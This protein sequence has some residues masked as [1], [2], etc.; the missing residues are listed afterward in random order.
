M[1]PIAAPPA[2]ILVLGGAG[3]IGRTLIPRLDAAGHRITVPTRRRERARPL[4]L[5]PKTDV[6]ECDIQDDATLERLLA[7]QTVVINLVGLLHGRPG[8]PDDPFGPDF[9]KAHVT[10]MERLVRLMSAQRVPRLIQVSALGVPDGD[11]ATAPSRYLRSKAAA[12]RL[13]RESALDWTI[14]RPS[15]VFGP[16]DSFLTLFAGLQRLLPVMMVA[17]ADA[18]FQPV[19]AGDVAT[20][21]AVSVDNRTTIGRTFELAGPR[22]YTLAELIRLTGRAS[23]HRRPVI[24]LPAG[25]GRLQALVLEKMPGPTLMS[26]DNLLSMQ[27]DNVA[28]GPI[29]PLF[30]ITPTPIEAIAPSYL[31][32]T[33]SRFNA[34]R[35]ARR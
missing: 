2:S 5:L 30:G 10:L 33:E 31:A 14:F 13:I 32:P 20:A 4:V 22:I 17:H 7:G 28:K 6:V 9:R 11:P 16:G 1:T 29:D 34:E 24:G 15:V 26:R 8:Q 3:F 35:R 23:G 12:E 19:Y 27:A 21:I 18:R 25:L